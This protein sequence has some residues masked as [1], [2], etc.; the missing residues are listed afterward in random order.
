[1]QL[2]KSLKILKK[3]I[4]INTRF[5]IKDKLEGIGRFTNEV[6]G[7]MVQANSDVEFHYLFDRAYDDSFIHANNVTGHVL[8]PPARH[9]FLWYWWFEQSVPK[10][11]KKIKPD[12]FLSTDGYASLKCSIPQLM[13]CHDLAFESY[14]DFVPF[15]ARNYY[16]H[17]TPKYVKQSKRVATV[18]AYTK[19]DIVNRYKKDPDLIDVI[20]NG[21]NISC[22]PFNEKEK[23]QTR[24]QFSNEAPFFLFV[25]AVHPRKNLERILLAFDLFKK[26]SGANHKLIVAGRMAW[27]TGNIESI[28]RQLEFKDDVILV[29]HLK[30]EEIEALTASADALCYCS[31]FEGFGLPIL[32]AMYAETP[33]ITSNVTSMPEVAGDAAI[34]VDPKSYESISAAMKRIVTETDLKQNLIDKGKIQREKFTWDKTANALWRSVEKCL[35]DA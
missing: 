34:L 33:V 12:L 23:Q 11:L 24:K 7:R 20:Y 4:A 2:K 21:S 32:E 28:Y 35:S 31:L 29:G 5:L 25:S 3:V 15:L 9:P 17:F 16:L 26:E 10:A 27:Q 1:M 30:I 19:Q 14:P 22:R 18:S 8:N 13:V 6:I